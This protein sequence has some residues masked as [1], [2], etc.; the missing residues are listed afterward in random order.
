MTPEL[1]FTQYRLG[2]VVLILKQTF[3]SEGFFSFMKEDTAVVKGPWNVSS[4]GGSMTRT[5]SR[6]DMMKALLR[7][8][9]ATWRRLKSST[10]DMLCPQRSLDRHNHGGTAAIVPIKRSLWTQHIAG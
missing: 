9:G 8:F 2:A 6:L 5:C 7:L 10:G 3:L 4:F 1:G